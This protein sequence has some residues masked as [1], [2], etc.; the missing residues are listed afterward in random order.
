MLKIYKSSA[1]SGKTYTLVREYLRLAFAK[2]TKYK[3][4][5]AITFTNKAAAEMKNRILEALEGISK[6]EKEYDSLKADLCEAT[7]KSEE[8][9]QREAHEILRSMLHN[10]ADISVSTIDSFVHKVV[11]AF[12]HDLQIPM[13]FDIEMDSKKLLHDAVALLL[14]RLSV[15]DSQI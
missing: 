3:N 10:Y 8:Q 1:G 2:T 13:N 9:L 7:G 14:D 15:S 4:I 6:G 12:A 5:L 11:R